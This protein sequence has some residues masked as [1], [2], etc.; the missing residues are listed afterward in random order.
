MTNYEFEHTEITSAAPAAVW[1]LWADVSR[2]T[3]WDTSL[4][5]VTLDGPFAAGGKGT[6]V[7]EGQPPISYELT[8]VI[9]GRGF[10]DVT[11]IPGAVLR[12]HHEVEAHD[13]RTRVTHRVEIEGDMAA[14]LG[15]MV[16]EDVP[17]AM[18][19]LVKLAVTATASAGA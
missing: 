5:S 19:A 18:R 7:I 3:E 14:E 6:M 13:G 8:E 12:F 9:E 1:A 11:E 17:D 2:W 15:P 4:V 16:T 10:T